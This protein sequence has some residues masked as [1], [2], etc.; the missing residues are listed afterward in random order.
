MSLRPECFLRRELNRNWHGGKYCNC[1]KG[2]QDHE[3][4]IDLCFLRHPLEVI[5]SAPHFQ[6]L[7]PSARSKTR[8]SYPMSLFPTLLRSK[9]SCRIGGVKVRF[10]CGWLPSD[11]SCRQRVYNSGIWLVWRRLWKTASGSKRG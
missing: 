7:V 5:W 8:V 11:Q 6:F 2:F 9:K 10:W 1:G 3:F 4:H